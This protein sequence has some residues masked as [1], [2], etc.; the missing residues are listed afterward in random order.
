MLGL[1]RSFALMVAMLTVV[2]PAAAEDR[3]MLLLRSCP[4]SPNCV[5]SITSDERHYIAPFAFSGSPEDAVARIREIL[6]GR[7]DTRILITRSDY[8]RV[9]FRTFLGFV[10]DGEFLVDAEAHCIHV[11]SASRIGW[12]DLGK[13]RRRLEEIRR[14]FLAYDGSFKR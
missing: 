5:S 3:S 11:R 10:D 13:N 4:S 7:K 8:L 12:W 6:A 1:L 2:R 9:E 14:D